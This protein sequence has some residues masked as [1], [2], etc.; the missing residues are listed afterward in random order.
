MGDHH[1][2]IDALG[3]ARRQ[4]AGL[5]DQRAKA[6][7]RA[8]AHMVGQNDMIGEGDVAPGIGHADLAARRHRIGGLVIFHPLRHQGA[9]RVGNLDM[10]DRGHDLTL[11]VIDDLVGLQQNFIRR[12][13]WLGRGRFDLSL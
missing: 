12:C 5:A 6:P 9:A 7:Q 11:I 4:T 13:K 10:A 2:A 3:T 8:V 1:I